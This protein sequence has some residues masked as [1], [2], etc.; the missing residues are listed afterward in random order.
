MRHVFRLLMS[1][2]SVESK[3][4]FWESNREEC[5]SLASPNREYQEVFGRMAVFRGNDQF[6]SGTST[7]ITSLYPPNIK[8]LLK[9]IERQKNI[10]L[11]QRQL[12]LRPNLP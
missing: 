9:A 8:V 2:P 11:L 7:L 4:S 1:S 12:C 6:I 10:T 3:K 5:R